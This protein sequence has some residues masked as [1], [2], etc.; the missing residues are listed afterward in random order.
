MKDDV[1]D[2]EKST[3]SEARSYSAPALE[4]GLDI[5]EI[6]CRT[7]KP[8]S[9]RDIAQQLGR[10][11]GEI[12]R[13]I[14]VLVSRNY[15]TQVDDSYYITT[16][17][18]ELSHN[19]PPTHR[20]LIE[21]RP[22]MQILSSQLDQACHLTVYGQG[23][24]I[25]IA[26]VDSPSG[27]GFSVRVGSEL[28]VIVSASGRVLLAF[29]DKE[30]RHFHIEESL[31]RRPEQVDPQIDGVLDFIKERGYESAPSV[32]V[33]GLYVVSYPILDSQ[34][35]AIAALTVPYAERIDQARRKSIP[36][37]EEALGDAARQL[38]ARIGGPS[39]ARPAR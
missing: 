4:K 30:T 1:T 32:Q 5:L 29:Q 14:A 28:D 18:F 20:L 21:A 12:Y 24:Q 35:H 38:C 6:L 3:D 25:V 15:V 34:N 31:K 23:R 22:L 2:A 17:L 13:M 39:R 16:K 36:E 27:M 26:K 33:R 10:S 8:L 37:I 11:V 19:N 7:E 9:Q